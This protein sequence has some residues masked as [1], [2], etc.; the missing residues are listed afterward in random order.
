MAQSSI[1]SS[2]QPHQLLLLEMLLQILAVALLYFH[3]PETLDA[4][5]RYGI[6][7]L[8]AAAVL[9]RAITALASTSE[10]SLTGNFGKSAGV[11]QVLAA[12]VLGLCWGALLPL[13]NYLGTNSVPLHNIAFVAAGVTSLAVFSGSG[14]NARLLLACVVPAFAIPLGWLILSSRQDAMLLWGLMALALL[15]LSRSGSGLEDLIERFL[16]ISRGN[17][18][19]VKNLARARDQ[20]L[21]AQRTAEQA[22][23][24]IQEEITERRKAEDKIKASEQELSRI[25]NDMTDTYFQ[26]DSAG[27]VRRISPSVTWMLG[28]AADESINRPWKDFFFEAG[29]HAAFVTAM[30]T[31]FG[32]LQNHEVRLK[33]SQGHDVWVTLNAHYR[34][35]AQGVADGFEGIARDTTEW[36]QAKERL[37]QEKELWRVT[38]E[39]IADGVITTDIN[40]KVNFLNP[41]AIKMTGLDNAQAAG[42]ALP[43]VM[44]LI[45]EKDQQPVQIPIQEWLE[46][47]RK[48]ALADPALLIDQSEGC[49]AAIELS[50]SPIRDSGE[51]I[52][53]S[54]MVF[55][56]VTKP[57]ALAMQ[58]SYQATHDALTGLINRVEFDARVEQAI[59]S[60]NK[61]EKQHALLYIDLDQFKVVNDTCGHPAGDELLQQ[62]TRLLRG[63][64]RESDVLARLGGDEFGV[65]LHGCPIKIAS[66]IAE[67]IRLQVEAYR[68]PHDDMQFRIGASI[69]VVPIR[70]SHTPLTELM[71]A[72]DSA[73]YVAKEKGRNCVHVFQPDDAEVAQHHGQM[74]WMQRIQ[75][76]VEEDEFVLFAQTIQ[77]IAQPTPD[78]LHAELLI[79]MVENKGTEH[80]R[81]IPPNAFLPAAERYHL[82]PSIDRWVLNKALRKLATN[83]AATARLAT[84]SINLSGQSLTDLKLY[85]YIHQLLQETGV[86][87]KRICFEITERTVIA[88]MEIARQFVNGLRKIGFRFALDDFGSGLST[89]D[90]L[91]QLNVDYVKLDGSLVRDVATSRVSQ[92][93]V[94]AVNY[95][96]HVM[97]MKSIAEYVESDQIMDALRKLSVDYAQGYAIDKPQRFDG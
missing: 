40:G 28:Y 19:L 13:F 71:K 20:A 93:M 88:N 58:L 48:A 29:D 31:A 47:G 24:A 94:H 51:T 97:G 61:N 95:V 18:D 8:L 87:P 53:G 35:N 63:C 79:R 89:F 36:R 82:M 52:I 69:G 1:A 25:L 59:H 21:D 50:G 62:V 49:E 43:E 57:R 16:Q 91:K 4:S 55:H 86:D 74:Q 77:P 92:A 12:M 90:Y 2:P 39:S 64:L 84:C 68:F 75:R 11:I 5:T 66:A 67:K 70:D 9:V 45:D 80:E 33:H 42:K 96:A 73:C 72:V 14:F 10:S 22:R 41:V 34:D 27:I 76:A 37:F 54:V 17:T 56:D 26:V 46:Y 60:A 85:D 78:R 65:L 23:V 44:R 30:E 3:L 32:S 15:A 7:A 83:D 38:L 6:A 81:I